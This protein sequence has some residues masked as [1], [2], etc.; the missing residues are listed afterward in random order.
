M[1]EAPIG[2]LG[3]Q[4]PWARFDQ[5]RFIEAEGV[6]AYGVFW[7]VAPPFVIRQ[8]GYRLERVIIICREAAID[9]LPRRSL[10]FDS[11]EIGC[12]EDSAQNSLRRDRILADKIGA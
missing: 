8:C 6:E 9:D 7:I 3:D 11:A 12:L 4:L 1:Q 5:A 10:R 2:T